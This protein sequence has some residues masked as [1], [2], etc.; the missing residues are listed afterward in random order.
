VAV[1]ELEGVPGV[2]NLTL[3]EHMT[4]DRFAAKPLVAGNSCGS[5]LAANDES[6]GLRRGS[7]KGWTARVVNYFKADLTHN[8]PTTPVLRF[9][10][11]RIIPK[12]HLDLS[13]SPAAANPL[14]LQTLFSPSTFTLVMPSIGSL[15]SKAFG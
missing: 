9:T 5:D 2:L 15:R 1:G 3:R 10:Q 14:A 12:S 13:T 11:S 6:D 8:R 4:H 7:E